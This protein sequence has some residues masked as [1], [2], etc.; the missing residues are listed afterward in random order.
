[1]EA[2]SVS[3]LHNPHQPVRSISFPNRTNPSSQRVEALLNHLKPHHSHPLLEA[4]T[5]QS[6]LVLLAELYISM[7]ELFHSP[8]TQQALLHY[9]DGKM[10]TDSLCGS[11]T[12][13]EACD[14]ARELLLILREHI[15][16]LQSAIRRRR[17]DSSIENN[18]AAY[19]CFRKKSKKK[20]SNQFKQMKLMQKQIRVTFSVLNQ[21]NQHLTLLARV[22]QEANT[23]TISILSS[24]LLFISLPA[25]GTTK[26]SSLIPS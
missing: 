18:I 15:Q 20:I 17:G 14:S 5:I 1:M 22:L 21:E 16:T 23:I 9:Q 13:L 3:K 11:V 12:L 26:G 8:Q 7:E 2:I 25:L 6:E 24:V 4:K 19:E 10:V